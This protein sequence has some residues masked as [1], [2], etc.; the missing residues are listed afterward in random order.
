MP[1]SLLLAIVG[2]VVLAGC[3]LD[4]AVDVTMEADGTG[5]VTVD[6]L[7]DADLASKVPTIEADLRL[8]D[9]AANGWV[10]EGPTRQDDGSLAIRLTHEFHSA[11]E[12][13]SVLNSIGPPFGNMRAARTPAPTTP[14]GEPGATTN[15]IDGVLQLPNGYESF[16]D[17]AL[18]E[19]VGGQ[20]F[21][22]EITA[23]G[24]QPAQAM[25][26]TFRVTLPGDV[27]SSSTGT[28]VGDGT[29]EWTAP[30]DGSEV[31]LNTETV[32]RPG[33]SGNGWA[34]PLSQV[35]LVLLVL[36]LVAAIAFIAFV[37]LA[38]R[39]KRRRREHA[40]RHVRR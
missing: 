9:A 20:P 38:R 37:A 30:L 36:W 11:D 2:L 25:S 16:A 18:L 24:L 4:V 5:V 14:D 27:V 6:A 22:D 32:Q 23:S 34:R 40:L 3:R 29:I 31:R 10:V 39:S 17:A 33:G 8:D 35:S 12:L 7:A 1:R 15:A 13:A 19:A 26:F 21:A 28:E